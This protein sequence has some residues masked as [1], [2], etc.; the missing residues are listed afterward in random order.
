MGFKNNIQLMTAWFESASF[1]S[2]CRMMVEN[3][4]ITELPPFFDTFLTSTH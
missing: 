4:F 2:I 1:Q 3:T